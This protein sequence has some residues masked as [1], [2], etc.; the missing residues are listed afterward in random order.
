MII[1]E[2]LDKFILE[3]EV[4]LE[5]PAI[6][7][8]SLSQF[9]E[10]LSGY[11][12]G[13]IKSIDPELEVKFY[14]QS[15]HNGSIISD[16][17]RKIIRP[18]EGKLLKNEVKGNIKEFSQE[19]QN[20]LVEELSKSTNNTIENKNISSIQEKLIDLAIDTNINKNS[21]YKPQN[22]INLAKNV[23]TITTSTKD[24]NNNDRLI[25]PHKVEPISIVKLNSKIDIAEIT[26]ELTTNEIETPLKLNLQAK[27]VDFIG[28]S[29]WKFKYNEQ[30]VEAKIF[31]DRWLDDFH[32][33]KEILSPGD[34]IEVDAL[35]LEKFDYYGNSID[36]EYSIIKIR[37]IHRGK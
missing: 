33:R 27:I 22:K 32:Q 34:L 29:K 36:K 11:H 24:L 14:L 13:I 18:D 19:S 3:Y 31:D 2:R 20:I 25:L 23:K 15:V 17:L 30:T 1:D 37:D 21:N 12:N 9:F 6:L 16:I 35:M 5:D 8:K 7:Y 4:D 28:Q 10:G 26:K